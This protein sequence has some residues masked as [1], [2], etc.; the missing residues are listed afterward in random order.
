M[1]LMRLFGETVAPVT[2]MPAVMLESEDTNVVSSDTIVNRVREPRH[3]IAPNVC[4]DDAP[5]FGSIDNSTNCLI[6][7][8][9][10]LNA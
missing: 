3:K 7:S 8:I 10:E 1:S 5:S 2:G 4:V 6:D 9:E